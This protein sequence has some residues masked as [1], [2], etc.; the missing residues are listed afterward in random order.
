M[1]FHVSGESIGD[2]YCVKSVSQFTFSNYI[3]EVFANCYEPSKPYC[4]VKFRK[5]KDYLSLL[6]YQT[7]FAGINNVIQV[8]IY[9]TILLNIYISL[10]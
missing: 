7:H 9:V 5:G 6:I 8:N 4:L 10:D 1:Q 3:F 2:K